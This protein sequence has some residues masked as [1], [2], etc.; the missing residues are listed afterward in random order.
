MFFSVRLCCL[1]MRIL[2]Y[3]TK[4]VTFWLGGPPSYHNDDVPFKNL[5]VGKWIKARFLLAL[6]RTKLD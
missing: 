2:N 6:D 3:L 4:I 5:F 1:A